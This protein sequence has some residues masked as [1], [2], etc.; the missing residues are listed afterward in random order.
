MVLAAEIMYQSARVTWVGSPVSPNLIIIPQKVILEI[1]LLLLA[2]ALTI[3]VT[4]AP[5][6]LLLVVVWAFLVP[7]VIKYANL[8][9]VSLYI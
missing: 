8:N 9:L 4:P 7:F 6:R 1:M 5:F 3:L 2:A